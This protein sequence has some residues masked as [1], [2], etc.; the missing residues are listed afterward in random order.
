MFFPF[1]EVLSEEKIWL[2]V[3]SLSFFLFF[4]FFF[5]NSFHFTYFFSLPPPPPL[6]PTH[7]HT[8]LEAFRTL[9][10]LLERIDTNLL[11][12]HHQ[13]FWG[14]VGCL[15]CNN[16]TLYLEVLKVLE[17]FFTRLDFSFSAVQNVYLASIPEVNIVLLY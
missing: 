2:S 6:L 14:V 17:V 9:K 5:L 13:I 12:L 7:H 3:I 8:A 4:F 1:L 10:Y 16:K 11:L 15:Y